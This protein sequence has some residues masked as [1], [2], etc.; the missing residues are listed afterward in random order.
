LAILGDPTVGDRQNDEIAY[1]LSFARALTN[2]VEVV[3]ELNGRFN[4]RSG[5]PPPGSESRGMLRLGARYTV[6][7][8]RADAALLV[9]ATNADSGLGITAGFT[10][11]FDAFRVP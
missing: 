10:Y 1:G 5:Q 8:W 6:G 7:G 2:A 9:G 11:V 3:G 4:S